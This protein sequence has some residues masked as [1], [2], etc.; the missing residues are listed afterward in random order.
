MFQCL[1]AAPLAPFVWLCI[2]L[3]SPYLLCAVS[4]YSAPLPLLVRQ[5]FPI[6]HLA[7]GEEDLIDPF[8]PFLQTKSATS[9]SDVMLWDG[10]NAA[11]NN[12]SGSRIY[13]IGGRKPSLIHL[14]H[15]QQTTV[16]GG[17]IQVKGNGDDTWRP[18]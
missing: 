5:P 3:L 16:N 8:N 2:N 9:E 18:F 17:K 7:K 4:L 6:R 13:S 11:G 12:V 1:T 10:F 14:Q 15:A